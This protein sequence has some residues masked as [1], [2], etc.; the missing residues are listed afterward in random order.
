MPTRVLC[1]IGAVSVEIDHD[2]SL[3]VT[4]IRAVGGRARVV[5]KRADGSRSYELTTATTSRTIST[6]TANRIQLTA[7]AVP[8]V[9]FDGADVHIEV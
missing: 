9:R 4:A 7:A 2:V 3:R 6:T 5:I 8:G 1:N